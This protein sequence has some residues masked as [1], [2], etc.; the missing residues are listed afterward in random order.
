M[1]EHSPII[2]F[3]LAVLGHWSTLVTGGAIMASIAFWEW[4]K[5]KK[6]H[7]KLLG[8]VFFAFLFM[9]FFQAWLDQYEA[10]QTSETAKEVYKTQSEYEQKRIDKLTDDSSMSKRG[11]WGVEPCGN[12]RR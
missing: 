2:Q 12:C 6:I 3:I 5:Q 1:Q 7:P 11:R 4:L 10:W 9:A 8:F